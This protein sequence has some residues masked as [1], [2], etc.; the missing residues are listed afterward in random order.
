L[1]KGEIDMAK[2]NPE[3]KLVVKFGEEV[4]ALPVSKLPELI[5]GYGEKVEEE[6]IIDS[7]MGWF[8]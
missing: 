3:V 8:D 2:K 5:K 1:N 7:I 4:Y 6:G